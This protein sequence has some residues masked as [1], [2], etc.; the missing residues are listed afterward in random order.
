V[1]EPEQRLAVV[2]EAGSW[3]GT[4]WHHMADKKGA[5]IDCAMLLVRCFC[6]T[7]LVPAFDPRPYPRDWMM[8]QAV[9]RLLGNV[10]DAGGVE[11]ETPQPG[12]IVL[13]RVGLC[14]S[15]AGIVSR[16]DGQS[17]FVIHA[18][19][20]ARQVQEDDITLQGRASD[21]KYPRRFFSLWAGK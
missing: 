13:W 4:P 12:D 14:L 16:I 1:T 3:I 5:G 17:V 6:D 18:Y 8:H 7:G 15:H 9:E 2:A 20:K 21:D 19:A 11:V 10:L